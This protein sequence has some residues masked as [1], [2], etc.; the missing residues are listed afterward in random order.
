MDANDKAKEIKVVG[1]AMVTFYTKCVESAI[2]SYSRHWGNPKTPKD[3]A[4]I[5]G[6]AESIFTSGFN[7]F[8]NQFEI[9]SKGFE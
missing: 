1:E 5:V 4:M 8:L 9:E 2:D 7:L 6:M 3:K